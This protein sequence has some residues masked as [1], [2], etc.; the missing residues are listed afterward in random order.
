MS[1]GSG[2]I[3]LIKNKQ[4]VREMQTNIRRHAAERTQETL[5]LRLEKVRKTP[6]FAKLTPLGRTYVEQAFASDPARFVGENS[7]LSVT[8]LIP[9]KKSGV[10]L[11]SE[12]DSPERPFILKSELDN[13][14]V[15][16]LD[17]PPPVHII[18]H[19]V[20]GR[21]SR[22]KI[23]LDFICFKKNVIE[24]VECKRIADLQS[25]QARYQ[26]DWV[27]EG[28]LRWRHLPSE[29]AAGRFGMEHRVFAAEELT[30]VQVHNIE[31][32]GALGSFVWNTS[33]KSTAGAIAKRLEQ[34]GAKTMLQICN[35]CLKA[36]AGLI[37]KAV[38]EGVLFADFTRQ[39]IDRRLLVFAKR[40]D[41]DQFTASLDQ[42]KNEDT[43]DSSLHCRLAKASKTELQAALKKKAAY[44]E[45][46]ESGAPMNA[47]DYRF[48]ILIARAEAESAPRIAAFVPDY[49]SRGNRER[50]LDPE[51]VKEI[52]KA[53]CVY[54]KQA[55]HPTL[56]GVHTSLMRC[57][58]FKD[59]LPSV[60]TI[61]RL[62]AE[63][64]A[65]EAAA[66]LEGG[67]RAFHAV[68]PMVD[69]AHA[70]LRPDIP[71]FMAHLDGVYGDSYSK[72]D[73]QKLFLR[74]IYYPVVD[75]SSGYV[76]GRGIKSGH[77]SY[78]PV[79]M[80][81]RDCVQRH[82]G[83]PRRIMRDWGKEFDN[84]ALREAAGVFE[85]ELSARPKSASRFGGK[86]ESFNQS[87]N[88]YLQ[89]L[90]GGSYYDQ[91]GR[92][93]DG[94]KKGR[95][96]AQHEFSE[97]IRIAD[98]WIFEI[99]NK[100]A[101]GGETQTPEELFQQSLRIMPE[102]MVPVTM[103]DVTRYATSY[104]LDIGKFSYTRGMRWGGK[105]YSSTSLVKLLRKSEKPKDPRIDCENPSIVWTSTTQG[106]MP[107]RSL[108][109]KRFQARD[110][111]ER[112][113][114]Q[115]DLLLYA[116]TAAK[117]QLDRRIKEESTREEIERS[118][119]ATAKAEEVPNAKKGAPKKATEQSTKATG[120]SGAKQAFVPT[121]F[122]GMGDIL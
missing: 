77:P 92:S 42:N 94:D 51:I 53:I 22:R 105:R 26:M 64:L 60:E 17:Q 56:G 36:T 114:A 7:L 90:A 116:R 57:E 1:T 120:S 19:D 34:E 108:D 5:A 14:V 24:L 2:G 11:Q 91:A 72:E 46:R 122:P 111:A 74:P 6:G 70:N 112:I 78:L 119:R 79:C 25:L 85:I 121:S 99:W 93:A 63:A 44:D 73:E 104:P 47:T 76:L 88:A 118:S 87:F 117:N 102:A 49:K 113:A 28:E 96:T 107:M 16:L 95:A 31:V 86:G 83:L 29:E 43:G 35:G 18:A 82:K 68:R 62:Y 3:A 23:T 30:P 61:R 48:R 100:T 81:L 20:R 33:S 109:Y 97:L 40:E 37:V 12:S 69:G 115:R 58:Q 4:K 38:N 66:F 84:H 21:K 71:G 13:D 32:L 8:S 65:P 101:R 45:R 80:A 52:K 55:K 98:N 67:K 9:S 59:D 110:F 54:W 41:R 27:W 50:R 106:P 103:T 89:T 10:L 75:D 39:F 15:C